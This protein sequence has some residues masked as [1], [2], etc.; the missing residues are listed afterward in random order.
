MVIVNMSKYKKISI[1]T[2]FLKHVK[3]TVYIL[4]I[5]FFIILL[6]HCNFN[7]LLAND[8]DPNYLGVIQPRQLGI[9]GNSNIGYKIQTDNKTKLEVQI[10]PLASDNKNLFYFQGDAKTI[11]QEPNA[12]STYK[13]GYALLVTIPQKSCLDEQDLYLCCDAN[14]AIK[15]E[16]YEAF[17]KAQ[18]DVEKLLSNDQKTKDYWEVQKKTE[19][20]I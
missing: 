4:Y 10:K 7:I 16:A 18:T 15:Q 5:V 8:S 9:N 17:L 3:K 1:L 11:G 13:R 6:S 14:I 2:T 20:L 12:A 19:E